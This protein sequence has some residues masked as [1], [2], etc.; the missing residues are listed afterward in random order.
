LGNDKDGKNFAE[1]IFRQEGFI[2]FEHKE[3]KILGGRA[4]YKYE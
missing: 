3:F 2:R 4:Q 1:D